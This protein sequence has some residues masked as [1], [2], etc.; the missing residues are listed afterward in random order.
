MLE[1][2]IHEGGNPQGHE[3]CE[4]VPGFVIHRDMQIKTTMRS[5][6]IKPTRMTAKKRAENARYWRGYRAT[7]TFTR[8]WLECKMVPFGM[9]LDRMHCTE[10]THSLR[11]EIPPLGKHPNERSPY[12]HQKTRIGIFPAALLLR[13]PN[14]RPQS[15]HLTE[16]PTGVAA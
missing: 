15:V 3:A 1:Q 5:N 7:G 2:A 9:P 8:C 13:A 4:K 16:E 6:Q 12:V 14:R 10:H 11:P